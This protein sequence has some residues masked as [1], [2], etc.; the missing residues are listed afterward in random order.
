MYPVF[1]QKLALTLPTSSGCSVGTVHSRTKATEFFIMYLD[2]KMDRQTDNSANLKLY[3]SN[4]G[5]FEVQWSI[6]K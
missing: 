4:G 6:K 2:E 3:V 5:K 1:T